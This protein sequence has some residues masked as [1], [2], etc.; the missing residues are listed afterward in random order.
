MDMENHEWAF[1]TIYGTYGNQIVNRQRKEMLFLEDTYLIESL[2]NA[3]K[4]EKKQK[5]YW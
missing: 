2:L 1:E 5:G 3:K 4:T